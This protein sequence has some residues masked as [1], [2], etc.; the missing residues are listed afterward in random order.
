LVLRLRVVEQA[1]GGGVSLGKLSRLF[2]PSVTAIVNWVN[3]YERGGVD[4]LVP[5]PPKPPPRR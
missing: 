3:A 4:A 2:G 5:K 1:L